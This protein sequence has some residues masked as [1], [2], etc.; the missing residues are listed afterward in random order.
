MLLEV[1]KV[2]IFGSSGLTSKE[3]EFENGDLSLVPVWQGKC[4]LETGKR[5]LIRI[6]Y[7]ALGA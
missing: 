7:L 5:K 6:T 3:N 4:D 2:R 1:L